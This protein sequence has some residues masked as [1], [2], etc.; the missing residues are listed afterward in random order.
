M[1]GDDGVGGGRS[2]VRGLCED[3]VTMKRNLGFDWGRQEAALRQ[4]SDWCEREGLVSAEITGEAVNGFLSR[5]EA[6]AST[7]EKE[8]RVLRELGEFARSMGH[9]RAY[10][11]DVDRVP[12]KRLAEPYIFTDGEVRRLFAAIDGQE[13]S[14]ETNKSVVDP[15]IF[16][17]LYGTGMRVSECLGLRVGDFDEG[18]AT[19]RVRSGKNG[20][21]RVL[22]VTERLAATLSRNLAVTHPSGDPDEFAFYCRDPR[23]G[24]AN[25]QVYVRF[26]DYLADADIPH[27]KRGGPKVHSFRHG[28]AVANLRRW[29]REGADLSARLPR[30]MAYMG[31]SDLRATEYYLRL[32]ADLYPEVS[33]QFRLRF[34]YVVPPA[35]G[36]GG[37]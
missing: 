2:E 27:F 32:T 29:A 28:F 23:K 4:F 37:R 20:R 17:V 11:C 26:R 31:H 24:M 30:L 3:L 33:E 7:V 5:R 18:V 16:R 34:G 19:L 13:P 8:Q 25:S 10:V 9:G 21:E 35:G 1:M 14:T 12:Y 22:P 15:V 6:K 36:E